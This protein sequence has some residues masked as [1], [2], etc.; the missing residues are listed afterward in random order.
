MPN[1]SRFPIGAAVR[2]KSGGSVMIV[3]EISL[4]LGKF[5]YRCLWV[6]TFGGILDGEYLGDE[7]ELVATDMPPGDDAS[8]SSL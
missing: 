1:E 2:L 4:L 8:T 7:L 3:K 5:R 6:D